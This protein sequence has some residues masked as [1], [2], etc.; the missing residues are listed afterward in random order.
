MEFVA[1]FMDARLDPA[2]WARTREDQGWHVLSVA[3][4]FFTPNRPFPHVW[5]TAS[6]MAMAT[7]RPR[8]TTAFVNNLF[9]SP[10][11][12]AQ[13]ALMMQRVAGGRFELGLGAGWA[14]DEVVGAGLPYPEP[15]DRAGAFIEAAQIVR[16]LLHDG[17][18]DFDGDYY[19]VHVR[20]LGPTSDP[21][22]PLVCSVGGPRTVR[23]VTPHCDRIEIKASS[24]S[25]RGGAVDTAAM[26]EIPD[27][28]LVEMIERVRAV[29]PD[30]PLGMFLF[31]NVGDDQLTRDLA[32]LMGD[33]LYGR[34]YGSPSKVVDGI[35]WLAALGI[36][37]CQVSPID[38]AS[39]DRLAPVLFG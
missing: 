34:F 18:C 4:H 13:A 36:S 15:R 23:E 10:V 1:N 37:R 28:H 31:C 30:I 5:V 26:A 16:A 32:A 9:R 3:D 12:V 8:I 20:G 14:R 19:R 7:E 6:A 11:E 24:P 29:D 2:A 38:D 21:P 25:T 35:A 33:G 17:A 22:P 27:A 39:F